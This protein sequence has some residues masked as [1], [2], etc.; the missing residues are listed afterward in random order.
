MPIIAKPFTFF[1]S[2][3]AAPLWAQGT[4]MAASC[5]QSDV[6][7]AINKEIASAADGDVI[8]IPPGTCTWTGTTPVSG[9][10]TTSVTI[11]G[12]GAISATT[13]GASTTGTDQTVIIDNLNSDWD[14]HITTTAGKPFRLTGIAFLANGSSGSHNQGI[15]TIDGGSTAVRVDHCHFYEPLSTYDLY[16]AGVYGVAD[17]VFF[18]SANGYGGIKFNDSNYGHQSWATAEQFGTAN[19]VY[20]EDSQ[21]NRHAWGD[22]HWGARIV[23]RHNT[24][25]SPDDSRP[26]MSTHA[27]DPGGRSVK[28]LE[29]YQNTITNTSANSA[30]TP[31]F[32][33]NGG[34][35]LFWGNTLAGYQFAIWI[36][37]TRRG[38]FT[39]NYGGPPSGLGYC[40]STSGTGWDNSGSPYVCMDQPGRGAGDLLSGWLPTLCNQT[41]G[42]STYT[43]Q[44][45]R[46]STKPLY[47]WNNS[48]TYTFGGGTLVNNVAS[49]LL[50][51]NREYYQQFASY[52]EPGSFDG[53]RGIGQG[54][55]SARPSNCTAGPGGN[56]AGVGYWATD[57]NTLYVCNP[58]N[59]W[60]VYYTP[61]IYPHP[62]TRSSLVTGVASPT[63]LAATV[64]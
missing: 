42:C 41:Q 28:Q 35:A 9:R 62:L 47:L 33:V 37:Y 10:F 21:L 22:G 36:D 24:V 45:P 55:L 61:Y 48:F 54:L 59:T 58:T 34:T 4:Y 18:D 12:A 46:Q 57:T 56:T 52:G 6:Q 43:G 14:L 63:S 7:I 26:S 2:A 11:Q 31:A 1:L 15:V 53:T 50:V 60:T 23:L 32:S 8:A 19:G 40:S 3:L 25:I 5:N 44:W 51:D 27:L 39:Y 30:G 38:N 16:F 49:P 64:H 20:V 13:G 29:I 17:H